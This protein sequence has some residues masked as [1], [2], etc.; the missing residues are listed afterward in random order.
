MRHARW[1]VLLFCVWGG[2]Y[3]ASFVAATWTAPAGDGFVRGL[4]R[5]GVFMKFQGAAAVVAL[6]LWRVGCRLP[7]GWPRWLS[8][9]P[10]LL[11][12][13]LVLLVAGAVGFANIGRPSPD[14]A[15]PGDPPVTMP[16]K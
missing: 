15:A 11:A 7:Q 14:S 10:A 9:A 4:N 6:V 12:L 5:L 3:G 13:G 8:R 1:A 16:I 2:L